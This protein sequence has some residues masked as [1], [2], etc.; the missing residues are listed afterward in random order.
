MKRHLVLILALVAAC[1][2]TSS[3]LASREIDGSWARTFSSDRDS[4]YHAAMRVLMEDGYTVERANPLGGSFVAKSPVTERDM[5]LVPSR[6]SYT[7]AHV[8]V[9]PAMEAGTRIRLSLW[10]TRESAGSGREPYNDKQVEE[11]EIYEALLDRIAGRLG[12]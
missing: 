12:A 7:L 11:R 2:G 3:G 4:V 1:K 6:Y 9:E 10:H 5:P 8:V